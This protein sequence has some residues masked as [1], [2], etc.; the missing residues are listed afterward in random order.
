MRT[1]TLKGLGIAVAALVGWMVM[2]FRR[3]RSRR[4]SPALRVYGLA[5]AISR[6][7]MDRANGC[8]AARHIRSTVPEC[9]FSRRCD[10]RA[11]ATGLT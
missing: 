5:L 2:R 7:R 6:F 9:G 3:A 1:V 8:D 11:I 10:A 4:R